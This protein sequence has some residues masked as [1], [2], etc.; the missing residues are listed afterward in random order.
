MIE[1]P[2]LFNNIG[3]GAFAYTNN[4]INAMTDKNMLFVASV[5]GPTVAGSAVGASGSVNLFNWYVE[6]VAN[7]IGF[8]S[9]HFSDDRVYHNGTGSIHCGT[10]VIRELYAE[11]WW[12]YMGDLD[13]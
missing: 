2:V 9:V 8:T 12:N 5:W 6:K 11:D 10:N 4:V 13:L 1:M 3:R 7:R